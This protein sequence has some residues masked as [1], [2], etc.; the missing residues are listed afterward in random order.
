MRRSPH[1]YRLGSGCPTEA[2][3]PLPLDHR[4]LSSEERPM[5]HVTHLGVLP[6]SP[7]VLVTVA[8]QARAAVAG[9]LVRCF[10]SPD[11]GAWRLCTL[12]SPLLYQTA[13]VPGGCD[14]RIDVRVPIPLLS[15]LSFHGPVSSLFLPSVTHQRRH[16]VCESEPR[17]LDDL[18]TGDQE[19]AIT[20]ASPPSPAS[21]AARRYQPNVAIIVSQGRAGGC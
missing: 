7:L 11:C 19:G 17:G 13:R 6:P 16:R 12:T 15:S 21:A 3:P 20:T 14:R 1:Q 9:P 10:A 5:P 2:E 4:H 18:T 8:S